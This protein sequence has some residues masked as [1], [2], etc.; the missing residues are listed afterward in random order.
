MIMLKG[1]GLEA[2]RLSIMTRSMDPM[3]SPLAS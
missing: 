2:L 3:F 1:L